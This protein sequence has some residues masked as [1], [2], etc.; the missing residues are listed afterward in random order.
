MTPEAI[1]TEKVPVTNSLNKR[2]V[3]DGTDFMMGGNACKRSKHGQEKME[4]VAGLTTPPFSSAEI[5]KQGEESLAASLFSPKVTAKIWGVA[6][7]SFSSSSPPTLFPEYTKPGGTKYVYR[8]LDFWTSGFFPGCLYLLLERRRRH[9]HLLKRLGWSAEDEPNVLHLEFACKWWT[10]TLHPNAELKTTHDLGFM[11]FPWARPAWELSGDR[12]SFETAL[13]AARS[14]YSRFDATVGS[15]RSW[16]ICVTKRYKFLDPSKDFLVIIDNMM[17]LDVIF[18]AASQLGDDDMWN[19]AVKH[20]ETTREHHIRPDSSTFHVVNFDQATGVPKEKITNQGHS[21]TSSWSRGQA[22]AVAGFAQT[23]GWTRDKSFLD[24]AISCADYFLEQL[25]SSGIPPWDFAAPK[26]MAQP[27]DISAS[28]IAAYG[29]LLIH[30]ALTA[31]G[32]PS[33]YLK[34]AIGLTRAT[35]NNHINSGGFYVKSQRSID[36]V[37]HGTVVEEVGW[38]VE[39]GDEPETILNGATINNYEFAPRRWAN[40]GLVYADYFF[41]LVGNK[42]LEMGVPE[43]FDENRS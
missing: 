35:C 10:E 13:T 28:M 4:T 8:E 25:P 30:E 29:M 38:E 23:Y 40:H 33:T 15:I 12:R 42:L 17:N 22:W 21:D 26:D 34:S 6:K 39:M 20:A 37:E 24:T 27:P 2:L 32:R 5:I 31:L 3:D 36:T 41:L 43:L 19:A 9:P 11:I 18:W 1:I 16:D 7:Q 14:L